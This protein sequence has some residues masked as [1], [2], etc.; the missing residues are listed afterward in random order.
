MGRSNARP[1]TCCSAAAFSLF[2]SAIGVAQLEDDGK[3]M[4]NNARL[5]V[6]TQVLGCHLSVSN[7]NRWWFEYCHSCCRSVGML[8]F[9]GYQRDEMSALILHATVKAD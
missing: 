4:I 2:C 1:G 5:L 9:C 6:Q 7:S 3:D 8:P